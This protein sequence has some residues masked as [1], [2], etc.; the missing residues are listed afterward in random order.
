VYSWRNQKIKATSEKAHVTLIQMVTIC[1]YIK[2]LRFTFP[3]TTQ[4]SLIK[5]R[6]GALSVASTI[7]SYLP[8]SHNYKKNGQW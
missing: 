7:I 8:N 6:V 2:T 5:Y 4:Q 1:S 3:R